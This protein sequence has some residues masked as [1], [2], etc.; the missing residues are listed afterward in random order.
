MGV[1]GYESSS[2]LS[3][4]HPS[5]RVWLLILSATRGCL[6]SRAAFRVVNDLVNCTQAPSLSL[7]L[8]FDSSRLL[9]PPR[10]KE[11]MRDDDKKRRED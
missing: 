4:S 5:R 10:L 1:D 11:T 6:S 9:L 7:S 3:F 8:P 2:F